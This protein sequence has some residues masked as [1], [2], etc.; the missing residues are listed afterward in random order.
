[1]WGDCQ[2]ILVN[3]KSFFIV[4]PLVIGGAGRRIVIVLLKVNKIVDFS[5]IQDRKTSWWSTYA[6]LGIIIWV[7][8]DI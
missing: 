7:T 8:I 3:N 4:V 5:S 2:I 6:D 1:V